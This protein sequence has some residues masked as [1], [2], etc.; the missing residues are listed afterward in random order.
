MIQ[1]MILFGNGC[2]TR[3]SN[4]SRFLFGTVKKQLKW[5][6]LKKIDKQFVKLMYTLE[7]YFVTRTNRCLLSPPKWTTDNNT[8]IHD[9]E[10]AYGWLAC[11]NV[12]S[13]LALNRCIIFHYS[14][15]D[16]PVEKWTHVYNNKILYCIQNILYVLAIICLWWKSI[17]KYIKTN[18]SM[19]PECETVS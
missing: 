11:S 19:I 12:Q 4:F 15:V 7:I 17:K 13:I 18:I 10:K 6:K 5:I 3:C 8:S 16:L 1:M 14:T 9:K 2:F